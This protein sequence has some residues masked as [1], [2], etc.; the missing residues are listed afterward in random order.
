MDGVLCSAIASERLKMSKSIAI[1]YW[2]VTISGVELNNNFININKLWGV[3]NSFCNFV[4]IFT[5]TLTHKKNTLT[6]KKKLNLAKIWGGE[7]LQPP[8]WYQQNLNILAFCILRN[9]SY[10][11]PNL[12]LIWFTL[13]THRIKVGQY[14]CSI[15]HDFIFFICSI[16]STWKFPDFS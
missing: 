6:H 4:V 7:G 1:H 14:A 15:K 11:Y 12:N 8:P 2:Q 16:R 3:S 5:L 13:A 9:L 10:P